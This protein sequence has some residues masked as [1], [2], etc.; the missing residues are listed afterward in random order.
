MRTCVSWPEAPWHQIRSHLFLLI[1]T[2]ALPHRLDIED[3][4]PESLNDRRLWSHIQIS[5]TLCSFCVWS[6]KCA[7]LNKLLQTSSAKAEPFLSYQLFLFCLKA[8]KQSL[9]ETCMPIFLCLVNKS[10]THERWQ[11]YLFS[12]WMKWYDTAM[13]YSVVIDFICF[14]DIKIVKY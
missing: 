7:W 14:Y 9:D 1:S 12:I 10:G 11:L 13:F 5:Y 2:A 6:R 3:S 8:D 4:S